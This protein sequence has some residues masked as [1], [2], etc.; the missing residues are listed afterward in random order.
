[1]L[2]AEPGLLARALAALAPADRATIRAPLPVDPGARPSA[3]RHYRNASSDTDDHAQHGQDRTHDVL[4][5]RLQSYNENFEEKHASS[6]TP[7]GGIGQASGRK[8]L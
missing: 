4:A 3:Q 6:L 1:M 8:E 2:A 7:S 5:K